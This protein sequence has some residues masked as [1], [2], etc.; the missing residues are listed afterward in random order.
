ME[1]KK[2]TVISLFAGC[3]G[4]SLG[5]KMAGFNELL[6]VE[7]E[8][9]AVKTFKLNFP[10]IPIWQKDITRITAKEILEFCKIKITELDILDGSP[11][12]QGFSISGKRQVNDERNDLFK[13]YCDLVLGLKPKVFIME[14]VSGM[15]KGKMKGKFIEIITVLKSLDYNVKCKQMNAKYYQVPQS[16]ERL[17][18]IGVRKDLDIQPIYPSANK[19]VVSVKD[20]LRGIQNESWELDWVNKIKDSVNYSRIKQMRQGEDFSK[21]SINGS[22]FGLRKNYN[23][24]PSYTIIKSCHSAS[25]SNGLIHPT[26]H[27]KHTITEIKRLQSF[28]DDFKFIGTFTEQWAKIGNSVPPLMIYAIAKNIKENILD[29]LNGVS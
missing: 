11:P 6:A 1:L 29:T 19:K 2:Y 14:N 27:R 25:S 8:D 4:S 13:S 18:F 10:E 22:G 26:E 3:G 15:A 5:Y 12:C 23:Y 24:K 28:P 9:N 21:Y 17:I 16:R 20:A 7:Y